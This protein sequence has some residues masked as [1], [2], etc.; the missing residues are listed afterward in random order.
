MGSILS[1]QFG[2]AKS[3]SQMDSP[4]FH[5]HA[6]FNDPKTALDEIAEISNDISAIEADPCAIEQYLA[7]LAT[8]NDHAICKAVVLGFG[9]VLLIHR[10]FL[11]QNEE[12][13]R[14]ILNSVLGVIKTG[15]SEEFFRLFITSL[16]PL[17]ED[18][19]EKWLGLLAL[20]TEF[21]SSENPLQLQAGLLILTN[22]IPNM[23]TE[24]LTNK[25]ETLVSWLYQA[26]ANPDPTIA[27]YGFEIFSCTVEFLD[28]PYDPVYFEVFKLALAVL[29]QWLSLGCEVLP[30]ACYAMKKSLK[31]D[32]SF[33]QPAEMFQILL[34]LAAAE[35][36]PPEFKFHC[37]SLIKALGGVQARHL[38]DLIPESLRLIM[39]IAT[40]Q[41]SDASFE[42]NE[43]RLSIG[44]IKKLAT[45]SD[46]ETFLDLVLGLLSPGETPS[47]AF[48]SLCA[49]IGATDGVHAQVESRLPAIVEYAVSLLAL[50]NLAVTQ[51]VVTLI[52]QL[53][54]TVPDG[55]EPFSEDL[56]RRLLGLA[57]LPSYELNEM[58][59]DA[60]QAFMY[61]VTLDSSFVLGAIGDLCSIFELSSTQSRNSVLRAIA[62]AIR[63]LDEDARYIST[64]LVE[65]VCNI[66]NDDASNAEG[67]LEG[68]IEV[69][70][71]LLAYAPDKVETAPLDVWELILLHGMSDDLGLRSASLHALFTVAR[72]GAIALENEAA[73]ALCFSVAVSAV[74]MHTSSLDDLDDLAAENKECIL[75]GLKL[76]RVLLKKFNDRGWKFFSGPD[77]FAD[78]GG[79]FFGVLVG[80]NH[81]EIAAEAVHA[82]CQFHITALRYELP[83][84][85]PDILFTLACESDRKEV[86]GQILRAFRKF[87]ISD[88]EGT[89]IRTMLEI[90]LRALKRE[91]KCQTKYCENEAEK[92]NYEPDIQPSVQNV[93]STGIH[94]Y[95]QEFP[96]Q[97]LFDVIGCI[98]EHLTA[99]EA[100]GLIGVTAEWAD[101][102]CPIPPDWVEF[103]VSRFITLDWSVPMDAI[104]LVRVLIRNAPETIAEHIPGLVEFFW[105]Q[106][107][108]EVSPARY[109]W[110]SITNMISAVLEIALSCDFQ[111]AVEL[112]RFI[113]PILAKL[114]VRGDLEE[115][116]FIYMT[117]IR[118]FGATPKLFEGHLFDFFRVLTETIASKDAW[119]ASAE[120]QPHLISVFIV[121]V[122]RL[123]NFEEEA[124]MIL[125]GDPVKLEN[126]QSRIQVEC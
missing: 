31:L 77:A 120:A 82:G 13:T 47:E 119:S 68:A 121:L 57:R 63:C 21:I 23:Q 79:Q 16:C 81:P 124:N 123:S 43:A 84:R 25:Q 104:Y 33:G 71:A 76:V 65:S 44:V 36:I 72:K 19:G 24:F 125:G 38:G 28:P 101:L 74:G 29:R 62:G 35:E 75:Y 99:I 4:L 42:E 50:E 17:I 115:A 86:V 92:F 59:L 103:S 107:V 118:L 96:M 30:R 45:G 73:P 46:G 20:M 1:R 78:W 60:I 83:S 55:I 112:Y 39:A 5:L 114:P 98:G 9:R 48:S 51:G 53:A 7:I 14:E 54:D 27:V 26:L 108:A 109:Y 22:L 6:Q 116:E 105:E 15:E 56:V 117:L 37:L 110:N 85:F 91:L 2:G 122:G 41:F 102:G 32:V 70:G 11:S 69:L 88:P 49:L 52:Y 111:G 40:I 80:H 3:W 67:L 90:T 61:N 93:L 95:G 10:E 106:L 89:G 97:D 126:L 94:I 64:D 87:I 34:E 113:G 66:V 100:S 18:I 58:A 8:S 12:F